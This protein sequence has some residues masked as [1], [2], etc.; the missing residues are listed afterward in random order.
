VTLSLVQVI[1]GLSYGMLLF[2][3]A[4]GMTLGFGLLRII[5]LAHGSYY[6][7]GGY[8]GIEVAQAT[9]SFWLA[10]VASGAAMAL[11]GFAMWWSLLKRYI[12]N[13]L[14]M[15]LL[16]F[17]FLLLLGDLALWR[18]GGAPLTIP[19]P[20]PFD[21]PVAIGELRFPSYRLVLIAAGGLVALFLWWLIERTRVGMLVRASV[22]DAQ[23][24][25][26]LGVN[27]PRVMAGVFTLS[28]GLA[29]MAGVLGG[30]LIGVY[31][32]A[33]VVVLLLAI[34][35]VILGGLGSLRGALL[36]ALI[37]GLLDTAGRT[38]FPEFSLFAIFAPMALV[39]V[40]RPAGLLGRG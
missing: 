23:M 18:F 3:L 20:A 36:A 38:L 30:P 14:A 26:G 9:G 25:E 37:V 10:L 6:L 34:V 31:P 17:G 13:E 40:L 2:L 1:N 4:A 5:N 27:V 7:L 21:G 29:G 16:T 11:L 8:I 24:V 32:G 12:S 35:V 28:A 33:D 19:A 39:L 22:N 15:V